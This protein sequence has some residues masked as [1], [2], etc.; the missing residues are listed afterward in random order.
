MFLNFNKNVKNIHKNIKHKT[1]S[2]SL[3]YFLHSVF[4]NMVFKLS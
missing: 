3:S 2:V 1:Q 4:A